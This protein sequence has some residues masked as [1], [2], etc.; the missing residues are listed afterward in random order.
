MTQNTPVNAP[1][2]AD[3]SVV[4]EAFDARGTL[5]DLATTAEDGARGYEQAA[6]HVEDSTIAKIFRDL[7]EERSRIAQNLRAEIATRYQTTVAETGSVAAAVHRGWIA[8]KDALTGDDPEAVVNAAESAEEYAVDQFDEAL[9][10]PFPSDVLAS[11]RDH[12]DKVLAAL[13]RIRDL[14]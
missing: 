4:E 3:E 11:L 8:I 10:H 2:Q 7:G 9:T 6:D 1:V 12:R 13:N 14:K 5:E